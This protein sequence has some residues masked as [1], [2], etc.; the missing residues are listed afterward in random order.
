MR[1]I[2]DTVS[3]AEIQPALHALIKRRVR[4]LGPN[5]QRATF[6]VID[7]TRGLNLLQAELGFSVLSNPVSGSQFGE[8]G[9][10]PTFDTLEEHRTCYEVVFDPQENGAIVVLVIPKDSNTDTRLL[11]FCTAYAVPPAKTP[12]TTFYRPTN[13]T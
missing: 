2:L 7:R 8:P 3:L 9:F 5:A 11:A 12:E 10:K 4:K 1:F 13:A 6:I